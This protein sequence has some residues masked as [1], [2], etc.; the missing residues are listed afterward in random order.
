MKNKNILFCSSEVVPFSK[1]GGLADVSGSLPKQIGKSNFITV[2][3]PLYN[4]NVLSQHKTKAVG[5]KSFVMAGEKITV[6]YH[7]LVLGKVTYVFVEHELFLRDFLYGYLDDDKR[8]FI[9]DYAILE[10]IG[11][12]NIKFDLIHLND[13]QTG[14]VPYLLN[15]HYRHLP[16]YKDIR[17]L[18]TIH[19]LQFHGEFDKESYVYANTDFNY[20]FIH[21]DKLNFLKS[22]IL[23]SNA[24]NTVSET[25]RE[26]IQTEDFGYML[27]GLL[28]SRNEDLY[29]ILNGIDNEIINP[30]TDENI[31][32]NFSSTNFITGKK[33]NKISFL[34]YAKLDLVT[35]I[36][37]VGFISRL[38]EQKGIDLMISTLE[39]A[40]A[41]SNANF[42]ILGSGEE[43]YENFFNYL[44]AKYPNRVFAYIGFSNKLAQ[45][46]YAASDIF[47]MP[48]K[49]EPCGL[50][51]MM[52][53][54]YGS[55]PVVRETGGLKDTVIPY[56]KYTNEG[57]G[58]SFKNYNAHEF[59]DTLLSAISLYNNNQHTFRILQTQA[60][61]KDFSLERMGESYLSLYQDILNK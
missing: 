17:T 40:I 54:R 34:K 13:W 5:K 38:A 4:K 30:E 2:I 39:E 24:I 43:K 1:T 46:L 55:L 20:D 48:S 10:Y 57:D 52:A 60:M 32:F 6:N 42:A 29:G 11:L 37:L 35:E 27:D 51:Q 7:S 21:F 33:Q 18:I 14:M 26:E 61:K 19:N 3:T 36:P 59:K 41:Q 15:H 53:M 8:F 49:F 23:L 50:S 25:Y 22:G 28:K 12:A 16:L 31:P 56:N 47:L 9:Y 45:Q 58:F 44:A